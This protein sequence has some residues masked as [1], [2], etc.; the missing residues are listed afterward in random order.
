M[1]AILIGAVAAATGVLYTD[2]KWHLRKDLGTLMIGVTA[3]KELKRRG[4]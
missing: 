3:K 2:A 4:Q 1:A